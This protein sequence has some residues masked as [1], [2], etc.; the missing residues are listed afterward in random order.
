MESSYRSLVGRKLRKASREEA[1]PSKE[2][3][4]QHRRSADL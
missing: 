1:T 2:A 4:L 3:L